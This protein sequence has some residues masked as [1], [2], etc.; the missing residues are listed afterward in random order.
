MRITISC[1]I[2]SCNLEFHDVT[3]YYGHLESHEAEK[4]MKKK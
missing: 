3:E 1:Q 4:K 2:P